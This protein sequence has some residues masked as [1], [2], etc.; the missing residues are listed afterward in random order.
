MHHKL[1]GFD[2]RKSWTE[3]AV[4][5]TVLSLAKILITK[6]IF[7]NK[8]IAYSENNSDVLKELTR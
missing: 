2:N 1:P 8:R 4:I 7:S 5:S 6:Y 3:F